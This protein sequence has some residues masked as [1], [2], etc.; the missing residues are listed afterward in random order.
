[1]KS[2]F[3]IGLFAILVT[4]NG[5]LAFSE[6]LVISAES[7]KPEYNIGVFPTINGNVTNGQGL[8]LSNIYVYALFPS[9]TVEAMTNTNGKFFLNPL[10]SYPV[11]EYSVDVYARTETVLSRAS[12]TFE[13]IEPSNQEKSGWLSENSKITNSTTSYARGILSNNTTFSQSD[14]VSHQF[15]LKNQSNNTAFVENQ[16]DTTDFAEQRY[17]S[18]MNLESDLLENDR[19]IQKRENRGAF[20]NF[21]ATLDSIV[22]AIFWDQYDFTQ[23]ISDDA[24]QAKLGALEEGK[25][26]QDAMKVYQ[27]EAAVPRTELAE[28]M[29]DLNI[30][31]GFTNST[32]QEPFDENGKVPRKNQD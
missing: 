4:F 25:T 23:K 19:E 32:L 9:E 16:T 13:I 8:P 24:Y 3:L 1:M 27:K 11:G 7:T 26:P 28:F 18:K 2:F 20:A 21:V 29:K 6:E 17:L 5:T 15:L 12:V 22:H 31:H 14:M 10:T 30:K